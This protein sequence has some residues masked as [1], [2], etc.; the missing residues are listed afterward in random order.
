MINETMLTFQILADFRL[1]RESCS[2]KLYDKWDHFIRTTLAIAKR[3][4]KDKI[5]RNLLESANSLK[6]G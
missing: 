6:G 5:T 3:D 4:V 2:T 1:L